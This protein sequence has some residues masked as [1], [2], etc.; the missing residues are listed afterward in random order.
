MSTETNTVAEPK[1]ATGRARPGLRL[2]L[3]AAAALLASGGAGYY[4]YFYAGPDEQPA[5]NA[6]PEPA[7]VYVPLDTFTVNLPPGDIAQYLQV[8]VTFRLRMPEA[9]AVIKR[10]A[11]EV[12]NRILLLLSAQRATAL[13]LPEGKIEL[14]RALAAEVN[15]LL[16]PGRTEEGP[17]AEALFTTF[18]VQ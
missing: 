4:F 12:R 3:L 11:P 7:P 10:R 9:E 18:I 8:G 14:A 17:V 16:A 1:V 6:K 5:D 2:V 15:A 13:M